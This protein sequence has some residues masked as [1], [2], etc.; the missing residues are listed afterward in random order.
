[1]LSKEN[2]I[3][4]ASNY[5]KEKSVKYELVLLT[6]KTI[7]FE[8]GWVFFYQSLK[9]IESGDYRDRLTGNAPIIVNKFNGSITVTGTAYPVQRYIDDYL[10]AQK[11]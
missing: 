2:A 1:M 9:Y 8:L 10:K 4:I 5:V 3:D 7:E 11:E 6:D